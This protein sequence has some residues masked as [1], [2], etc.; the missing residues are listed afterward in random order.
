[1]TTTFNVREYQARL[2][3]ESI[4]KT[5]Q[6]AIII[7]RQLGIEYLWIDCICII[8]NSTLDWQAE[9]GEM[10]NIY[11]NAICT[12]SAT[13]SAHADD[14]IFHERV[15]P[16]HSRL[17][18]EI[19]PANHPLLEPGPQRQ[20]CVERAPIS[21]RAW[22]MQ[23]HLLSSRI[24]HWS[25]HALFWEC[26]TCIVSEGNSWAIDTNKYP[27]SLR[28]EYG[29][30]EPPWLWQ[31]RLLNGSST[32]LGYGNLQM[33]NDDSPVSETDLEDLEKSLKKTEAIGTWWPIVEE[34]SSRSLSE[35]RDRLPGLS[36]L[37]SLFQAATG[38]TYL[39]GLW[40]ETIVADLQWVVYQDKDNI[41][42]SRRPDDFVA[43][44]WSWASVIGNI[45]QSQL[46]L[47][48][49]VKTNCALEI[50]SSTIELA[51]PDKFGQVKSG[52]LR[53]RGT[54]LPM[55]HEDQHSPKYAQL[56]TVVV[57]GTA[58]T[59]YNFLATAK[60]LLPLESD[61]LIMTRFDVGG[62]MR[63]TCLYFLAVEW[64][65]APEADVKSF[66]SFQSYGLLLVPNGKP[67]EYSRV[68]CAQRLSFESDVDCKK[69]TIDIV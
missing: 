64:A 48:L 20:K 42:P 31:F 61:G 26:K 43:P 62:T 52:I 1:M 24:V 39:A 56:G 25:L 40:R 21:A 46:F 57:D 11:R 15:Q 55:A 29:G 68:G 13:G 27:P 50:L 59:E 51:G 4:P 7:T 60:A 36:G 10:K 44:S 9:A 47:T 41:R 12:I 14:G 69:V 66:M 8:Q 30:R 3:W 63:Y 67:N 37:A 49:Q 23:E 18:E 53:V 35:D 65:S 58:H 28:N 22:T 54:L 33:D 17:V 32:L 34:Y 5:L 38:H 45:H 6:D 19:T 2:P 16:S